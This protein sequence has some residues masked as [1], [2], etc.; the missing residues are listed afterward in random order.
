MADGEDVTFDQVLANLSER[1]Y[2]DSSRPV[3]PLVRPP[4]AISIDTTKL[5]I[6]EVVDAL[7]HHIVQAGLLDS[8]PSADYKPQPG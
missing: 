8:L 2:T 1:D 3:A 6:G 5:T 4:G 7:L